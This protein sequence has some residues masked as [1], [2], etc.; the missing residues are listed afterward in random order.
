MGYCGLDFGTS[1]TTFGIGTENA[2]A[3]VRLESGQTTVP[4]AVFFHADGAGMAFGRDAIALFA[5]GGEGRLMRSLKSV[6]GTE[7]IEQE[8]LVG[9]RRLAFRDVIKRFLAEIKARGEAAAGRP[10]DS[11]VHGRPVH[12]VD[13]GTDADRQAEAV[14]AEIAR[15]VGF[16]HVSF[17]LEPV[18]AALDY[19]RQVDSEEIALVADIGGGTSDFSIIRLDPARQTA[20]DRSADILA[21]AG[22]RVGGT[23]FDQ[24]LSLASAMPAL[25]YGSPMLK[26][27]LV[28]PNGYFTDLSTWAKINFLYTPKVLTELRALRRESARPDLLDRL[29]RVAEEHQGHQLA[30]SVEGAKIALGETAATTIRL[31]GIER[32]LEIAV[33]PDQFHA[34]TILLVERVRQSIRRCL[35]DSGVGAGGIDTVFL[36][37]GS[38]LLP[39]LRAAILAEVPEAR[40]IEGDKFGSVGLGLTIEA[41]RRYG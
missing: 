1:N 13:N 35:A 33:T 3:L 31:D 26:P 29:I 32:G 6:L 37:G 30:A 24:F 19:E 10:L 40:V 21:N 14:L 28:A 7:L 38:T 16:R 2:P 41:M 15:E 22:I 23:D 5:Q 20:A 25:G 11:V 34:A 8:T 17:Q 39:H 12:F 18:A 36:T 9:R 4:S 27:G